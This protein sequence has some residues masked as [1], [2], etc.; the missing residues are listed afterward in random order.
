M[1]VVA[2]VR[3]LPSV[4]AEAARMRPSYLVQFL[5]HMLQLSLGSLHLYDELLNLYFGLGL[6]GVKIALDFELALRR[7]EELLVTLAKSKL[8]FCYLSPKMLVLLLDRGEVIVDFG[9]RLALH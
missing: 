2:H 1:L 8:H 6:E 7:V 9:L 5:V 4:D 3:I